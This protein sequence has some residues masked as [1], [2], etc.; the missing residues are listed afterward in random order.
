MPAHPSAD[1]S[2]TSKVAGYPIWTRL[3]YRTARN[4]PK[5][6]FNLPLHPPRGHVQHRLIFNG[7]TFL[8]Q[9]NFSGKKEET[10]EKEKEEQYINEQDIAQTKEHSTPLPST[11]TA[12]SPA[13]ALFSFVPLLA[14]ALAA[15]SAQLER[16]AAVDTSAHCGQWDTI[17]AA[18]YEL[19]LD[20]W[21]I[22]GASGSQCGHITSLS[23]STIAWSTNWTWSGGN[24]VKTFTDIQLNEGIGAQLSQIQ[25]MPVG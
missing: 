1:F 5:D 16:A 18:P 17:T 14:S 23:G 8:K 12:M 13:F 19:L 21:G 7:E 10:R 15:P 25:S 11:Y 3:R 6:T 9:G 22:S 2:I 4:L 24:G 20:Q